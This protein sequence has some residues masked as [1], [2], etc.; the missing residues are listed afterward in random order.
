M[1]QC[2]VPAVPEP[3]PLIAVDFTA[4]I[5]AEQVAEFQRLINDA[6][7]NLRQP[8]VVPPGVYLGGRP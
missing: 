2:P 8:I 3:P 7:R 4:E 6:F 1:S 5:T